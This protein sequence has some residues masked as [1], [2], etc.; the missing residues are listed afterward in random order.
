LG[1]CGGAE[2]DV[3][4]CAGRVTHT[5]DSEVGLYTHGTGRH[6]HKYTRITCRPQSSLVLLHI[7]CVC[8][9]CVCVCFCVCACAHVCV[10]CVCARAQSLINAVKNLPRTP[11]FQKIHI[12]CFS[13]ALLLYITSPLVH[14]SNKNISPYIIF[15]CPKAL[16]ALRYR[17]KEGLP[18]PVY[19]CICNRHTHNHTHIHTRS[20]DQ[21]TNAPPCA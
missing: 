8:C 18:G 13:K 7:L 15:F 11:P 21:G 5:R 19:R 9:V 16:H 2:Q 14:R 6:V 3:V 4:H 20:R 12:F 17:K 10:Q 1:L